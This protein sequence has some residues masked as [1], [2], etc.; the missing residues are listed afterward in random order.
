MSAYTKT[1]NFAAKDALTTG[2]PNKIVRGTD[3]GAEFDNIATAV[4]SK[5][6]KE[7]PT[8]TGTVT[9]AALTVSGA[10]TGGTIDGGT[11]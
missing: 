3:I 7:S 9:L 2:D 11:Y 10:I 4:N 5:S 6:D 8:F 1:T